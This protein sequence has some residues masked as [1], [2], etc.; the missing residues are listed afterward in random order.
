M[1]TKCIGL[2]DQITRY[3]GFARGVDALTRGRIYDLVLHLQNQK[4]AI[5]HSEDTFRLPAFM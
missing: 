4:E 2:E 1:C 5:V 3:L